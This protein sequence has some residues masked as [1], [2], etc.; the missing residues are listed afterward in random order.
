MALERCNSCDNADIRNLQVQ[1]GWFITGLFIEAS[2]MNYLQ[3]SEKNR[4][5]MSYGWQFSTRADTP[6]TCAGGE[7]AVSGAWRGAALHTAGARWHLGMGTW[8]LEV[9][10]TSPVTASLLLQTFQAP[11]HKNV[12]LLCVSQGTF[13][14]CWWNTWWS[15]ESSAIP[16][17]YSHLFYT[18]RAQPF[19]GFVAVLC[20]PAGLNCTSCYPNI[21]RD[22]A[23][24][25]YPNIGR[26]YL[27]GHCNMP[28]ERLYTVNPSCF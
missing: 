18:A 25:Y 16:T 5:S 3:F 14:D 10:A 6:S 8:G 7:A 28:G 17:P 13:S 15:T 26:C 27:E 23:Q 2:P 24:K 12:T 11:W 20:F 21:E 1:L 19:P 22:A 9:M 4:F